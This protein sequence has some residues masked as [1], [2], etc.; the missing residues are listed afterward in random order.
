MRQSETPSEDQELE[1][2][3]REW[4]AEVSRRRANNPTDP[5]STGPADQS[6]QDT[7]GRTSTND[8]HHEE[9]R[10]HSP[11][12]TRHL[13][14]LAEDQRK[15]AAQQASTDGQQTPPFVQPSP[16]QRFNEDAPA[17]ASSA[18][19]AKI[20]A[21]VKAYASAVENERRGDLDAGTYP[22]CVGSLISQTLC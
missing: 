3:R 2:F 13:L 12:R 20:N 14:Q 7:R 17:P 9:A 11:S 1:R 15:A 19:R 10:P 22:D 8:D 5:S 18:A 6:Y 16:V 4:Q 21:A